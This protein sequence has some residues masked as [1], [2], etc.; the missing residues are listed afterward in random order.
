M[1]LKIGRKTGAFLALAGAAGIKYFFTQFGEQVFGTVYTEYFEPII[2]KKITVIPDESILSAKENI[3]DEITKHAIRIDFVFL[4]LAF[5]LMVL[6][7]AIISRCTIRKQF[8]RNRVEEQKLCH[9]IEALK[10]DNEFIQ[11]AQLYRYTIENGKKSRKRII[12]RHLG[13]EYKDNT[14]LNAIIRE[15]FLIEDKYYKAILKFS[16]RYRKYERSKEKKDKEYAK[17]SIRRELEWIKNELIRINT[18]DITEENCVHFAI[19]KG[20][21]CI[22]GEEEWDSPIPG[23]DEEKCIALMNSKRTG[24]LPAI[25]LQAVYT[26]RNGQSRFKQDRLYWSF[27]VDPKALPVGYKTIIIVLTL[28]YDQIAQ[29]EDS[30]LTADLVNIVNDTISVEIGGDRSG[31]GNK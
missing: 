9:A 28:S 27:V 16:E 12:I 20:V 6:I 13:S 10:N 19:Y 3:A 25:L 22:L 17:D 23:C 11:A 2:T 14:D 5:V 30:F 8:G 31:Q 21:T 24:C 4:I 15:E 18:D 26:F 29:K 7:V 1:K